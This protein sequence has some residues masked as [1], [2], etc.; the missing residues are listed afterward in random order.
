M[1]ESNTYA[2]DW[3]QAEPLITPREVMQ[4]EPVSDTMHAAVARARERLRRTISGTDNRLVV[5]AG[6]CSVHDEE[7]AVAYAEHL[8]ALQEEVGHTIQLVMRVYMEKPRTSVGWTGL[9]HDPH[10]DSSLDLN[11]GLQRARRILRRVNATGLD[12]YGEVLPCAVEFLDLVVPPYINDLVSWGAIGART[13]ESQRHRHLA[14]ASPMPIGFKNTR[15]GDVQAAVNAMVAATYQHR[16]VTVDED[17]HPYLVPT[18]GNTDTHVVLRGS[19]SGPNWREADVSDVCQ[20][21]HRTGI[22]ELIGQRVMIDCS[23]DNARPVTEDAGG[24]N[25]ARQEDVFRSA[26][27]Q[28][29][30]NG[31]VFGAMLESHIREGKQ[32][33]D[34]SEYPDPFTSV[35]DPCIDIDTTKELIRDA[36]KRIEKDS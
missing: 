19:D 21:I 23:H 12:T 28:M 22:T 1:S 11:E 34:A 5:I 26:V 15:R 6:P 36:A 17:A 35:T 10:M 13:V 9:I 3:Q 25:P 33:I 31:A 18:E 30:M 32:K 14:S 16:I 29:Q 24:S 20:R 2:A 27:E 7:A 8:V 4:E